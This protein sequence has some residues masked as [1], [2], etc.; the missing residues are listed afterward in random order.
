MR[1]D[2]NLATRPY[3]D[4]ALFLRNWL[5][6]L[7][8]AL[9][10]T[11]VLVYAAVAGYAESRDVRRQVQHVRA[12]I[13]ELEQRRV[14]AAAVLDLHQNRDVRTHSAF[15][16]AQFARK[17]FSWTQV[18]S[19]LETL[20][21]TRLQVVSIRPQLTDDGRLQVQLLV[22][23][24]L[25][26]RAIELVRR[27]E[28]SE[29]FRQPHVRSERVRTGA[30]GATDVQVQIVAFYVPAAPPPAAP[31]AAATGGGR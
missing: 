18:F 1:F 21:P 23:G 8:A 22:A 16:N 6:V 12:Q 11:S 19:D 15:L 30:T 7:G 25:R 2:L 24:P 9:L 29:R 27:M 31:P 14:H 13:A 20:M 3:E 5:L 10:L 28:Q 26:E 17:T 4:A